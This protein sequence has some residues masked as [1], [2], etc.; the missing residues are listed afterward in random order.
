M[1]R[2]L[3]LSLAWFSV[4]AAPLAR[5]GDIVGSGSTFA[6]PV[7]ARWADAYQR[8]TGTRVTFQPIGSGAGMEALRDGVVDF[9]ISDAPMVD[10][11]L[12][13]D[14]LAQ[15]PLVIGAIVPVVNL[16]GVTP[17]QMHLTGEV[18]ARVFLGEITR[19][20]DPA[21]AELNAELK[22]PDR[23]ITVIYRSDA[24]GTTFNWTDFLAKR[25][26]KWLA[27]I[28]SD[29][30]VHWPVGFG[31][32]GSGGVADKI[33]RVKGAIGYVEYSYAARANLAYALVRNRAGNYA[34]PEQQSFRS[35]VATID[36]GKEP[37]FHV[38]V[39]DSAAADAWPVMATSFALLRAH[40][41]DADKTTAELA[42]FHWALHDGRDAAASLNYLPL[43]NELV[44]L[45]EASWAK[46]LPRN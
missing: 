26:N 24:S 23:A 19:W 4:V 40:E 17:G 37:D 1:F 46:F 34:R 35:A 16:D 22:L 25:S 20:N 43:P 27:A 8:A 13:R 21:I 3:L 41:Q 33:A 39:T 2:L 14:G 28:G 9:A 32:K 7:V 29:L 12:L 36:W 38:L 10:A 15:F 6:F 31:G 45:I 5:A 42:F 11:Q 44:G 30:I 18:L